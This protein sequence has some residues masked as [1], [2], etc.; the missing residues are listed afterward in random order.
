MRRN[1]M[2]FPRPSTDTGIGTH[3]DANC[4]WKPN[5]FQAEVAKLKEH[6]ISWYLFFVC[7]EGKAD[8]ARCLVDNDIMPILR[9]WPMYF[10]KMS[11]DPAHL[12]TYRDVG[13]KWFE[14]GNE[15]NLE[16]EWSESLPNGRE[17]A[18]KVAEKYAGIANTVRAAG[19]WPLTP[20]LS[21]GGNIHHRAFF[22]WF[23]ERIMEL[24][25]ES[26]LWPGGIGLHCRP[27][28]NPLD[29]GP[30]DYD[31]S[32]REWE[33]YDGVIQG[34]L[35][36]R[37]PMCNTEMGDQP[38]WLSR[39]AG[40]NYDWGLWAARNIELWRW[41]D[42]QNAGYRYPDYMMA[43]CFWIYRD[44]GTWDHCGLVD[45]LTH[46]RETGQGRDTN[47]W[48]TM[49]SVIVW[50]RDDEPTPPPP[51]PEEPTGL[52]IYDNDGNEKDW[53][54]AK[55]KYNVA[56][57]PHPLEWAYRVIELREKIG[58]SSV[59]VW[60]QDSDGSPSIGNG[61]AFHW[62]DGEHQ[63]HTDTNGKAGFAYGPGAYYTPPTCGP[64]WLYVNTA[65]SEV[66]RCLGMLA[67]TNHAHLNI[68]FRYPPDPER[69][70]GVYATAYQ[71]VVDWDKVAKAGYTFTKLRATQ[72]DKNTRRIIEDSY[73]DRNQREA[74]R[75]GLLRG[76]WHFLRADVDII[77]QAETAALILEDYQLEMPFAVDVEDGANPL[78]YSQV[79]DFVAAIRGLIGGP[80][81]GYT[82][83]HM[84]DEVFKFKGDAGLDQLWVA[85]WTTAP[86]PVLPSA[87]K[88][89]EFWQY[90]C[91]DGVPGFT[92]RTCLD[93]FNGTVQQLWAKYP[94]PGPTDPQEVI[95]QEALKLREA[96]RLPM[97]LNFKYPAVLRE[98]GY[99]Q[100][101]GFFQVAIDGKV[102]GG[103]LGF[104]LD[105]ESAVA[106][107]PEDNYDATV[108]V[109]LP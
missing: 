8:W 28:G 63:E 96:M 94:K 91:R 5:D 23:M 46:E 16:G 33:W 97:P 4:G 47:L 12:L 80:I 56:I 18:R 69:A 109:E 85:S 43:D 42:P 36:R 66:A 75:V 26:V 107:S 19:M 52:K 72:W 78:T 103:Q 44:A 95:I 89:W 31:V 39:G 40:G 45:N 62:P 54:W 74:E 25:G 50:T 17:A 7:D 13:V 71:G 92:G 49:P 6:G 77:K 34:H 99:S 106:Y 83:Y 22:Q 10:P 84:W 86:Q 108:L 32:A 65:A 73:F 87:W 61:V 60:V 105:G 68:T 14:V 3:D 59:D 30:S 15:P 24:G 81:E 101:A 102:W 35:G 79:T 76:A 93:Y 27:L 64:H 48:K 57:E 53:A 98:H 41:Y 88:T 20:A 38:D 82:S 37:L 1:R 9:I 70:K 100:G 29:K 90:E 11:F 67:G 2:E 51:P 21:P 58:P 55:A 104:N